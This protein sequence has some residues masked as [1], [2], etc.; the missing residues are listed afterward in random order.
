[1][2]EGPPNTEHS[3]G[4]AV[5][6][7]PGGAWY[8]DPVP[9]A[10][11]PPESPAVHRLWSQFVES[12]SPIEE[13]TFAKSL[14]H[15]TQGSGRATPP[16]PPPHPGSHPPVGSDAGSTGA[17]L[18]LACLSVRR[19]WSVQ[20]HSTNATGRDEQGLALVPSALTRTSE[21]AALRLGSHSGPVSGHFKVKRRWRS[22]LHFSGWTF[23]IPWSHRAQRGF[24]AQPKTIQCGTRLRWAQARGPPEGW[25]AP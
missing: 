19:P 12:M 11:F 13:V 18:C 23:G 5:P 22:R 3:L 8:T 1:M 15:T 7:T 10:D 2:W 16:L 14:P 9:A 20:R 4:P 6:R 25:A 24:P 21:G 17:T